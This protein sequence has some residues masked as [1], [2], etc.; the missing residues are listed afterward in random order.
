[1]G[2]FILFTKGKTLLELFEVKGRVESPK[3]V[4]YNEVIRTENFKLVN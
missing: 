3:L 2:K 4:N 1:M